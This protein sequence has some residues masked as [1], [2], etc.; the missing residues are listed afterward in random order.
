MSNS[1]KTKNEKV[2]IS[3]G[4]TPKGAVMAK[5]GINGINTMACIDSYANPCI[6]TSAWVDKITFRRVKWTGLPVKLFGEIKCLA[7]TCNIIVELAARDVTMHAAIIGSFQF[8]EMWY[9]QMMCWTL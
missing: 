9:H 7:E 8:G 5:I 4:Y 3:M 2:P 6:L 1:I